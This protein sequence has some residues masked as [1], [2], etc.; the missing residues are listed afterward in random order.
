MEDPRAKI[1]LENKSISRVPPTTCPMECI[2]CRG[3]EPERRKKA[4]K[5]QTLHF[6]PAVGAI[7]IH[8][9]YV[10][11]CKTV[12]KCHFIEVHCPFCDK[13]HQH[14]GGPINEPIYYGSRMSHCNKGMYTILPPI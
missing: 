1:R 8:A 7:T 12:R 9:S 3:G 14:G 11:S 10:D 6:V 2:T 13:F 5:V 4:R